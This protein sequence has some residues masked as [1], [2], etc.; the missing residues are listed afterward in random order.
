MPE[1]TKL[2]LL[3]FVWTIPRLYSCQAVSDLKSC[4]TFDG[5]QFTAFHFIHSLY[6]PYLCF[7]VNRS[8]DFRHYIL[9]L[10]SI[11]EH[12]VFLACLLSVILWTTPFDILLENSLRL[13]SKMSMFALSLSNRNWLWLFYLVNFHS[14]DIKKAGLLLR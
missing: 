11:N 2:L 6:L 3:N 14:F 8:F 12:S 9:C 13:T 4:Q 1:I 7:W 5:L 10:S